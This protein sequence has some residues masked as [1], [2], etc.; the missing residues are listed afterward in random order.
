M[1]EPICYPIEIRPSA[2][3]RATMTTFFGVVAF[4]CVAGAAAWIATGAFTDRDLPMLAIILVMGA[5]SAGAARSVWVGHA[6]LWQDRLELHGIFRTRTIARHDV[7]GVRRGR[8]RNW[9]ME[10]VLGDGRTVPLEDMVYSNP[11]V[12]AWLDAP[13]DADAV[14][15]KHSLEALESDPALGAN[16]EDRRAVI[17]R[18]TWIARAGNAAGG[19][20]M[21]W[22]WFWPH[23]YDWAVGVAALLPPAALALYLWSGAFFSLEDDRTNARPSLNGMYLMPAVAL[24]TRAMLDYEFVDPSLVALT[25]LGCGLALALPV[26]WLVRDVRRSH[27]AVVACVF[28]TCLY[29]YGVLVQGN[30]IFD[31]SPASSYPVTVRHKH[32]SGGRK[33]TYYLDVTAWGPGK[34]SGDVTVGHSFYDRVSD[35]EHLCMFVQQGA[36]GLRWFY[37]GYC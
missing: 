12:Q 36:F 9:R 5:A 22:V 10:V 28:L 33:T 1:T 37:A 25:V 15:L 24:V 31:R 30:A 29:S 21:I 20:V 8:G 34:T 26:A 16:T 3:L 11:A 27:W 23:P 17:R 13:P 35:G 4:G 19:L 18:M 6:V 2:L 32:M 7:T 14:Q